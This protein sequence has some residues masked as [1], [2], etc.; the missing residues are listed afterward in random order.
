METYYGRAWR[1]IAPLTILVVVLAGTFSSFIAG[2]GFP[3]PWFDQLRKPAF[4]PPFW[5]LPMV[6]GGIYILLGIAWAMILSIPPTIQRFWA[7]LVFHCALGLTFFQP[8][9][10]F[11]LHDMSLGK[12]FAASMLLLGLAASLLFFR[13]R[14]PAAVLLLPYVGWVAF[15][16]TLNASLERMNPYMG[17]SILA[18]TEATVEAVHKEKGPWAFFDGEVRNK[19]D[20]EFSAAEGRLDHRTA[21]ARDARMEQRSSNRREPSRSGD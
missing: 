16:A 2:A 8:L 11:A 3:N 9:V 10:M 19:N 4:M 17:S 6:W 7:L 20:P 5:T 18:V 1:Q 15:A 13:L 21:T 14:V 12:L